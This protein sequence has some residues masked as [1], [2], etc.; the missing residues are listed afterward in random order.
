MRQMND[1]VSTE[2]GW[3]FLQLVERKI[4]FQ[5]RMKRTREAKEAAKVSDKLANRI[6]AAMDA[7]KSIEDLIHYEM[8]LQTLDRLCQSGHL[9]Y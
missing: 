6:L 1:D 4:E 9:G 8:V 2:E 7:A 5:E 3:E